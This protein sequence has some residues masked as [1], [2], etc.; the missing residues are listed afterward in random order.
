MPMKD[1]SKAGKK[2]HYERVAS[3]SL[4]NFG[5]GFHFYKWH[6]GFAVNIYFL[7]LDLHLE[8]WKR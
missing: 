2:W 4:R 8:I 6:K 7:F 1:I 5:M 3:A